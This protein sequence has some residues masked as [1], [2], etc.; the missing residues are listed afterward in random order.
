MPR[1]R[2]WKSYRITSFYI[3][4]E[5]EDTAKKGE[6]LAKVE[7]WSFSEL[8]TQ[9]LKEYVEFH[10]P[11]NPQL[12]LPSLLDPKELKPIRLEARFLVKEIHD[13]TEY[14]KTKENNSLAFWSVLQKRTI[15]RISKLTKLNQRLKNPRIDEVIDAAS[16]ILDDGLDGSRGAEHK[17]G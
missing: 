12:I 7:G 3:P 1:P 11:G 14:L 16:K 2:R 15:Q 8:L 9:A 17:C 5:F 10:Y 13:A 6:E 4:V